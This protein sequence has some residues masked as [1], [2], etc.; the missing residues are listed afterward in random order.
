MGWL[1]FSQVMLGVGEPSTSQAS[2]AGNPST[3]V[4]SDVSLGPLM[5]GGA[6]AKEGLT[7]FNLVSHG[8]VA[9]G[10]NFKATG[11]NPGL[12]SLNC[13]SVWMKF[14][15]VLMFVSETLH[16]ESELAHLC[17]GVVTGHTLIQT[18]VPQPD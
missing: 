15:K 13:K 17:P 14:L 1:S 3:T 18:L 8:A 5:M 10:L 7:L 2:T 9:K 12:V 16:C 11:S 4:T 6:K